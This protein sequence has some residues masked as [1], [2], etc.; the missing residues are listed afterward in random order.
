[1]FAPITSDDLK[2]L[3]Q[4]NIFSAE[5]KEVLKQNGQANLISSR[6]IKICK[7]TDHNDPNVI[8]FNGYHMHDE[9]AL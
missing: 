9:E 4:L 2:M 6:L 7:C 3:S 5:E 1:M 8:N